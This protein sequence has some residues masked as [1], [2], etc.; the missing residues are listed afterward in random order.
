M[1]D[2]PARALRHRGSRH[3]RTVLRRSRSRP[4]PQ[5]RVRA[6]PGTTALHEF[7]EAQ[8]RLIRVGL[9]ALRDPDT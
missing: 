2:A 5:P 1:Q 7:P 8:Q 4:R 3:A 6:A 9:E